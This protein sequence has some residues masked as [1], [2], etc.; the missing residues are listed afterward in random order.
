MLTAKQQKSVRLILGVLELIVAVAALPAG[1]ALMQDPTGAVLGLEVD[2][3]RGSEFTDYYIPGLVLFALNGLGML[4]GALASFAHW[5]PAGTLGI[6][7]G[8][9]LVLWILIQV[10][11]VGLTSFLQAIFLGIGMVIAGIGWWMR[12]FKT[13]EPEAANNRPFS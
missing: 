6:I 5:K 13:P 7:L 8:A 2:A 11:T 9:G 4:G 12:K 10:S 3:L 1:W